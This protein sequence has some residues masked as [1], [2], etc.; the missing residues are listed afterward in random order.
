ML[1]WKMCAIDFK[2]SFRNVCLHFDDIAWFKAGKII[3][4]YWIYFVA[5]LLAM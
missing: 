3:V 2:Q 5:F 1:G 4:G